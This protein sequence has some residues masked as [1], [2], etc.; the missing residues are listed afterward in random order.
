MLLKKAQLEAIK[1]GDLTLVFRRWTR[2][3]VK[4]GGT[5]KT[6]IGVLAIESV[7]QINPSEITESD[8]RESG[9]ASAADLLQELETRQGDTYRIKVHFDGPDPRVKLRE[10]DQLDDHERRTIRDKLNRL[11][12]ASRSGPWTRSVLQ[13][14]KANPKTAAA[15]LASSLGVEKEWLKINVRK[16]KNLGL[17]ISHQP[18]YELSPRGKAFLKSSKT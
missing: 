15:Q 6:A 5:L 12:A 13:A 2:P 7:D 4:S 14:I 10:S 18:G 3:S 1:S 17:T 16:L 11:D 8:A 9:Y